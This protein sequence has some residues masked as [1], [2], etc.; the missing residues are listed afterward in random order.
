M[1]VHV[2]RKILLKY[3]IYHIWI[4]SLSFEPIFIVMLTKKENGWSFCEDKS[5]RVNKSKGDNFSPFE[6]HCQSP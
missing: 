6:F 4:V 5:L 2:A 1:H 3:V